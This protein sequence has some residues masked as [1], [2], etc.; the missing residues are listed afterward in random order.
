M[1][2]GSNRQTHSRYYQREQIFPFI[3]DLASIDDF[4]PLFLLYKSELK[5]FKL[6]PYAADSR[7]GLNDS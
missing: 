5:R 6:N 1:H 3:H 4:G 2:C 7:A